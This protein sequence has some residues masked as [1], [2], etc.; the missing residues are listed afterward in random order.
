MRMFKETFRSFN[1][2]KF[3]GGKKNL[4]RRGK[5]FYRRSQ[6]VFDV[7]LWRAVEIEQERSRFFLILSDN[8]LRL[9]LILT[10]KYPKHFHAA[11]NS[12]RRRKTI[13]KFERTLKTLLCVEEVK[14]PLHPNN[15]LFLPLR[16]LTCARQREKAQFVL[17]KPFS[18]LL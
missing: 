6:R 3:L 5:C 15:Q 10:V 14:F 12:I 1:C 11:L 16:L 4:R 18:S 7:L 13:V 17:I 9:K 8:F 2:G